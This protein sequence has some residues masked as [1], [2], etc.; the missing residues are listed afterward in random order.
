M[1]PCP[2]AHGTAALSYIRDAAD[3]AR[4]AASARNRLLYLYAI[5][6]YKH[7][8]E[9]GDWFAAEQLADLLAERGDLDAVEQV[10]R[11]RVQAGDGHGAYQ[12]AALLAEAR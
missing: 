9:A 3:T 7:A 2:S 10:L 6:L 1:P 12:L 4:L 11:A 5:P 8:T